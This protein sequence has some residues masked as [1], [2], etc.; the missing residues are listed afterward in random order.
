MTRLVTW[1]SGQPKAAAVLLIIGAVPW[2]SMCL[3]ML[4]LLFRVSI[5]STCG[6]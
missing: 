2:V 5:T 1:I 6:A 4:V 3:F